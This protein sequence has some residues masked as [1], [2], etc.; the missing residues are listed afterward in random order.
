MKLP[1]YPLHLSVPAWY[2][3]RMSTVTYY[4]NARDTSPTIESFDT[5]DAAEKRARYLKFDMLATPV[6]VTHN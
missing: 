5:P 3:D 6:T 4:R 1:R 2:S